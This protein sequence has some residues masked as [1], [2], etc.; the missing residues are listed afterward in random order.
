[1]INIFKKFEIEALSQVQIEHL[2]KTSS[3]NIYSV[4]ILNSKARTSQRCPLIPLLFDIVLELQVFLIK[5]LIK[6]I[7]IEKK[8]KNFL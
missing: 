8:N 6:L 3:N 5:Q 4:E 7:M 2:Y 1:M